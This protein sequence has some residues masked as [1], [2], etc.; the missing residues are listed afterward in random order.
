MQPDKA[1]VAVHNEAKVM[2]D[3]ATP[4]FSYAP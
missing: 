3:L 4:S 2:T 1:K